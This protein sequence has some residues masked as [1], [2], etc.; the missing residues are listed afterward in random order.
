MKS[1]NSKKILNP[2][3]N[4]CVLKTG[5]T[6]RALLATRYTA[7]TPE[8]I[9]AQLPKGHLIDYGK[10]PQDHPLY[11]ELR[12]NEL[13]AAQKHRFGKGL[14]PLTRQIAEQLVGHAAVIV[15]GTEWPFGKITSHLTPIKILDVTPFG[16][17]V[18]SDEMPDD[19]HW[20]YWVADHA[21]SDRDT[22][23]VYIFVKET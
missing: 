2:K 18:A 20:I 23:H 15:H 1:C 21:V 10:V 22:E 17:V 16:P 8:E 6:G 4:R 12:H 9:F 13:A 5:R 14:V 11:K 3:S 7:L 19:E